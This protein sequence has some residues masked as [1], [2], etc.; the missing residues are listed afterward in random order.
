MV[1]FKYNW[2]YWF[3][4]FAKS[5]WI[6]CGLMLLVLIICLVCYRL[7]YFDLSTTDSVPSNPS[8]TTLKPLT[9][10]TTRNPLNT[11]IYP[12][13]TTSEDPLITSSPKYTHSRATRTPTPTPYPESSSKEE[14]TSVT[15][16][17]ISYCNSTSCRIGCCEM[18]RNSCNIYC[19]ECV[20]TE[21]T[22]LQFFSQV[23]RFTN[24]KNLHLEFECCKF[25]DNT[26]QMRWLKLSQKNVISCKF[27]FKARSIE[28]I[29]LGAFNTATFEKTESLEMSNVIIAQLN[30]DMFEGLSKI[31]NLKLSSTHL[32]KIT[33]DAFAKMQKLKQLEI[34]GGSNIMMKNVTKGAIYSNLES[35]T[36]QGVDFIP[37]ESFTSCP[38]LKIL[39]LSQS[40][41][42]QIEPGAFS[43]ANKLLQLDLSGN[44]LGHLH[45]GTVDDIA[46]KAN[47]KINLTRNPWQCDCSLLPMQQLMKAK[48][49][50][51]KFLDVDN[52]RCIKSTIPIWT[53]GSTVA[54]VKLC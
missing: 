8:S 42:R 7:E 13:G 26:L 32:Q 44:V 39:N 2:S 6:A 36:L 40:S 4:E 5:L 23:S 28:H 37:K 27:H 18:D 30:G 20:N 10:Q 50:M 22:T 24:C 53:Y 47:A 17:Y 45:S 9:V 16:E 51:N 43:G 31:K 19:H 12:L 34:L 52:V 38:K 41:L 46:K 25:K 21:T 1:P 49:T 15:P 33:T 29:A 14:E 11:T 54:S 48:S 35:L 3:K